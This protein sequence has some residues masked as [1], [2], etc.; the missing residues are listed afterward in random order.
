MLRQG[1]RGWRRIP[2]AATVSAL[3]ASVAGC[4]TE[5]EPSSGSGPDLWLILLAIVGAIVVGF[6]IWAVSQE[7][8]PWAGQNPRAPQSHTVSVGADLEADAG[9]AEPGIFV[10]YRHEDQTVLAHMLHDRIAQRFGA[11]RTFID[12]DSIRPGEDWERALDEALV[13]TQIMI[14]VIGKGWARPAGPRTANRLS[15]IDDWV[16]REV[17]EALRRDI[18]VL[19]VLANGAEMPSTTELPEPLH[20][21]RRRQALTI[22]DRNLGSDIGQLLDVVERIDQQ[23]A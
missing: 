2:L 16:R 23:L 20:G 5:G 18:R 8:A 22:N 9:G 1:T 10:S 15:D 21:L 14:V 6:L 4:A 19:T 3:A 11:A 12:V 7:N 17:E 13:K